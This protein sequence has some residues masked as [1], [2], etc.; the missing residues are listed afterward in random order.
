MITAAAAAKAY[1]VE[2]VFFCYTL[3]ESFSVAPPY[4]PVT[5]C[6]SATLENLFAKIHVDLAR[7]RLNDP[8]A[9]AKDTRNKCHISAG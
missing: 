8:H 5:S 1:H 3:P 4:D 7:H 6:D 2:G 9:F